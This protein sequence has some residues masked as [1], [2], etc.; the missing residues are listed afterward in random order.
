M[1]EAIRYNLSHLLDFSGR[2]ARKTFWLYVLFLVLAQIVIG[3]VASIPMY[4]SLFTQTFEAAAA[5]ADAAA[6]MPEI[7]RSMVGNIKT[8]MLVSTVLGL[9]LLAMMIAAIVRR[10]HDA[11]YTGWIVVLPAA[12]Q[13][14]SL[15]YTYTFIDRLEEIMFE[16]IQTADSSQF[17]P[18]AAQAEMGALGLVGWIGI[19]V[20]IGFGVLKS[21]DGPNKYGDAPVSF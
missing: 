14:F 12:T 7:M 17:D 18:Y 10:L 6:Q 5:G 1:L 8:Q 3:L 19:I 4:V 16:S 15:A 11:G 21:E 9:I 13:L 20:V 2:D